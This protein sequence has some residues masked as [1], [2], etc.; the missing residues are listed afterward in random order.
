V[1]EPKV[2]DLAG[3]VRGA[4]S[5]VSRLIGED[6]AISCHAA[7]AVW[8]TKLDQS[9]IEQVLLNLATN[10]RDAMPDGGTLE[11]S[12]DNQ[13]LRPADPRLKARREPGDYVRLCVSD[14]GHGMDASTSGRIFEPFFTTKPRGKGTG[15][16]LA[17]VFGTVSQSGGFIDVTSEP[18]K[19]TRLELYFPRS[20]AEALSATRALPTPS[21]G[22][23]TLLLVEDDESVRRVIEHVLRDAGYRVLSADS[24]KRAR[25]Q[26]SEFGAEVALVITDEVMPGGRGT[27]LVAELRE[28]RPQLRA[29][30][31][32]GY[33][34][35]EGASAANALSLR[36]IQ[37][38]FAL[39]D[40]LSQVRSL[41]DAS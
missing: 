35:P 29:L 10:A 23:E 27:D 17:M 12:V 20:H 37:K 39:E 6:V 24:P 5:M 18:G 2:L 28:Q 7:E 3:V 31:M 36:R 38:P 30:S 34:E 32:S 13:T 25:E 4:A 8:P 1:L 11:L 19:G 14:T 33:A 41:L 15:L 22:N 40:L 16:G 26:W 9:L 21:V